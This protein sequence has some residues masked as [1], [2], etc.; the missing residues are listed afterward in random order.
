MDPFS[1]SMTMGGKV[2]DGFNPFA[3]YARQIGSCPQTLVVKI[4]KHI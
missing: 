1:T 3:Q 4:K 2:V